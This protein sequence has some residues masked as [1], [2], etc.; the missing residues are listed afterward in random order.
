MAVELSQSPLASYLNQNSDLLNENSENSADGY[1]VSNALLHE[2]QLGEQLNESVVQTRRADFSLMLAMLADDVREQSQ[3]ILPKTPFDEPEKLNDNEL[4]KQFSL[5]N[6]AALSLET[7]NDVQQF[8]QA[9]IIED[10]DLATLHLSNVL[11]PKP[12]AF[13]D[14]KH[15]VEMTVMQNTSISCQL[16]HQQALTARLNESDRADSEPLTKPLSFNAKAWLDGIQQSIVKA[17]LIN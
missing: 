15:H 5:P 17:P 13:R 3:F 1:S 11:N 6:K 8:N 12:L 14:D 7:P 4:R 10:N 9:S 16:K 2:L